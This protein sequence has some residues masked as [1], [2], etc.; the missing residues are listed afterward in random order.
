MRTPSLPRLI[1]AAIALCAL[2][3]GAAAQQPAT[4]PGAPPSPATSG[5]IYTGHGLAMHG[6]LKY[7]PGFKAFGYV[8]PDAPKS[9]RLKQAAVGTFDSFNPFIVRGNP[10]AG[11]GQIYD[12]L[13]TPSADEPF[14][15]YGLL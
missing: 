14:S 5:A 1:G 8:N 12:T 6:D 7:G 11:I 4:A 10:A 2:A 13:L 3:G 9:G 15:E